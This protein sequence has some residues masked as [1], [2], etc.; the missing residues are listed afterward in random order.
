MSPFNDYQGICAKYYFEKAAKERIRKS[1]EYTIND[2]FSL[3]SASEKKVGENLLS[4]IDHLKKTAEKL[5]PEI[6]IEI[7]LEDDELNENEENFPLK[8]TSS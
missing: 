3:E 8:G 5:F 7:N 4:E 1:V 2:L 6:D